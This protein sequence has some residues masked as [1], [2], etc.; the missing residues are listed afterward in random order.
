VPE[1]VYRFKLRSIEE[2]IK[3][4]TSK[5]QTANAQTPVEEIIKLQTQ[6]VQ[7]NSIKKLLIE[8]LDQ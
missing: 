2:E 6:I 4:V 5:L 8:L 3:L 7:L 1:L